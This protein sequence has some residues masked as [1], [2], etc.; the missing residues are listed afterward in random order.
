MAT[1]FHDLG[2]GEW[3]VFVALALSAHPASARDVGRSLERLGFTL[4]RDSLRAY[5]S[6][7]V[8]KGYARA[9]APPETAEGKRR[10]GRPAGLY[11]EPARELRPALEEQFRRW[12]REWAIPE[13][14]EAWL[15][16]VLRPTARRTRRGR[17]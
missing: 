5:L 13:G 6:R 2:R 12:L 16:E 8:A 10:R 17:K 14:G 1:A 7:C 11:F 9:V 3:R 4:D 15:V